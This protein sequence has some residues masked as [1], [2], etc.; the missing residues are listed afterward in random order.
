MGRPARV[1]QVLERGSPSI[2]RHVLPYG[3]TGASPASWMRRGLPLAAFWFLAL[4]SLGVFLP[5]YALYLRE[6]AGLDGARLGVVLASMQAAGLL[7]Q[8]LWGAV[9]DRAGLRARILVVL[10]LGAAVGNL[11]VG[12]ATS[13]VALL[14]AAAFLD[15]FRRSVI[16]MTVSTTLAAFPEDRHA[17]GFVRVWG[18]VGFLCSMAA[19]PWLLA[20][21][22]AARGMVVSDPGVSEPG[23]GLV[24]PVG[25]VLL[26]AA[27][28]MAFVI[29]NRGA[30][31]L[32]AGRGEWRRL[33]AHRP[34]R[35]VVALGFASY[36]AL[37]APIDL[38]PLFVRARGGDLETVRDLWIV[39]L[40]PEIPLVAFLGAGL[41]RLGPRGLLGVG[42]AAA[43]LRWVVSAALPFGAPVYAVQALH[44]VT[45]SA[46]VLGLPLY[47]EGVVPAQLRSTGQALLG[48]LGAGLGGISSN[49]IAGAMLEAFGVT[50]VYWMGGL[51]A[52]GLTVLL[53]WWLPAPERPAV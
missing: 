31:A 4:G 49:L 48:M 15:V 42:L 20:R 14:A 21:Y 27:A 3:E 29:P 2:S 53:P 24:F 1:N 50:A 34:F 19:F 32:R 17:F 47:V 46:L 10:A 33:V 16:P 41:A 30:L 26:M 18:T 39:M 43:G 11:V 25:A 38:F 52:L 8:P 9:A 6:N 12:G 45:V 28:A 5:Y 37:Q 23:L 51:L 40:L 44:A 22:Q 13:F 36:L 35:R 7:A